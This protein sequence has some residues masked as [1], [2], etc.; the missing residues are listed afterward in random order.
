VKQEHV[1]DDAAELQQPLQLQARQRREDASSNAGAD[2]V[3]DDRVKEEALVGDEADDV[4]AGEVE[5][6]EGDD[7]SESYHSEEE[8]DGSGSEEEDSDDRPS[9]RYVCTTCCVSD[10]CI[11]ECFHPLLTHLSTH[12]RR[13]STSTASQQQVHHNHWSR[14]VTADNPHGFPDKVFARLRAIED[15]AEREE[16]EKKVLDQRRKDEKFRSEAASRIRD[17]QNERY[18][19]RKINAG[20]VMLVVLLMECKH[21]S[22]F[23]LQQI[24][25][26]HTQ[27]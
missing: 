18:R 7:D 23:I 27:V 9:K 25:R 12:R 1:D 11:R 4:E 3:S 26:A 5:G 21:L 24:P 19:K 14:R 6:E 20:Y 10:A 2:V 15:P 22:Y 8:E 16:A 17:H 13:V